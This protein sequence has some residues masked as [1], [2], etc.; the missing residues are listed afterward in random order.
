MVLER[1]EKVKRETMK[2]R[3]ELNPLVMLEALPNGLT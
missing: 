2:G 1:R 3:R